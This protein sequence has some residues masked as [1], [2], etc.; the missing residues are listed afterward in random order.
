MSLSI[1]IDVYCDASGCLAGTE[2]VVGPK[3][4][5]RGARQQA[6]YAGWA[7]VR[8]DRGLEDRC[9]DQHD[10]PVPAPPPGPPTVSMFEAFRDMAR[11]TPRVHHPDI[12]P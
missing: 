4:D 7:R 3:A 1:A 8:T 10:R 12:E 11:E 2:G 6:R 9:P 5:A